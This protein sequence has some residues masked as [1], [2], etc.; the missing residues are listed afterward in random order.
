MVHEI[1]VIRDSF[2]KTFQ[3]DFIIFIF[4][5]RT[6]RGYEYIIWKQKTI[7]L[8]EHIELYLLGRIIFYFRTPR[9][10]VR[11]KMQLDPI[12]F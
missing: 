5:I 1:V 10:K 2:I 3:S 7:H 4:C 9:V 6:A 11:R 12:F 8:S